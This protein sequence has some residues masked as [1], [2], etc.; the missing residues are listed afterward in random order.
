MKAAILEKIGAS[1]VID[2]II[3]PKLGVGQVL[4]KV[5]ASGICGA[6]IGEIAGAKGPDKYLPH[7][8]GHEGA[9]IVEDIGLGVQ[10]VKKGDHVVIHWRKGRGIES[11]CPR[12]GWKD[13]Q[14]GGGWN[15][16]FQEYSVVSENRLTIISDD[17]SFDIAALMGC[18]VTTAFGLINNEAQ[19][20]VGQSVAVIGCGG[21]GLNVIQGAVLAGA[22]RILA[23]DIRPQKLI[24]ALGFGA[25]EFTNPDSLER[26]GDFDIV[27]DTTG[28]PENVVKAYK[29]IAP[30]GKIIMVGQICNGEALVIPNMR[31]NFRGITLMDSCGGHANPNEDIPRYLYLYRAG[32]LKLEEMITHRFQ[33]EQVNEAL[34]VVRAGQSGRVVLEM[35]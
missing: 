26:M 29:I 32:R 23:I 25:N 13:G 17:I 28:I 16:T 14:V 34:D 35:K 9:G 30:G 1:L 11:Q 12:Y 4:V 15:T 5:Y 24:M 7:L 31:E 22:S 27:V 8:L 3:L 10:Y 21:V 20:K 6:Q 33:L 18:A 2:D 19:L